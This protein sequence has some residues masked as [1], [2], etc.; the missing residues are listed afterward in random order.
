MSPAY[1]CEVC[2][3]PG[4]SSNASTRMHM[5]C[6]QGRPA[7]KPRN[8]AMHPFTCTICGLPGEARD[9]KTTQHWGC[10]ASRPK[11]PV[12]RT[13]Y[14]FVCVSCGK[15]G[16]STHSGKT[17]HKE[18]WENRGRDGWNP[19][20]AHCG[21]PLEIKGHP[22]FCC[23]RCQIDH[24]SPTEFN[25]K[26]FGD[27]TPQVAYHAGMLL[28]DGNVLSVP[29]VNARLTIKLQERD[30]EYLDLL[31]SDLGASHC[32]VRS[33]TGRGGFGGGPMCIFAVSHPQLIAD[34]ARW[35]VV[36]RKTYNGVPPQ[37]VSVAL[38]PHFARGL[39]DGDGCIGHWRAKECRDGQVSIRIACHR[40][41]CDWL[42]SVSPIPMTNYDAPASVAA[43][44]TYAC[45]TG[46]GKV[47]DALRWMGY[48]DPDLPCL[49]RKRN[50]ALE[51]LS[52]R[53]GTLGLWR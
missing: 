53:S 43:D 47:Q 11:S 18:C 15:P 41:V 44:L 51:I 32:T 42:A 34:L 21:K 39:V 2:G 14:P 49:S 28:A 13:Q 52:R 24:N 25:P 20:C 9:A 46:W 33:V 29:H 10:Y 31:R 1:T 12:R 50:S 36:P 48:D 19:S 30:R 38:V 4:K 6:Y 27:D 45:W 3:K 8:R 26:Y 37:R 16:V 40:S 7:E 22:E 17:W 23:R 5:A 35:G